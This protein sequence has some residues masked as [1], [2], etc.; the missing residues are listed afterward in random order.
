MQSV[1]RAPSRLVALGLLLCL[2]V[3][4][5]G[6]RSLS[7]GRSEAAAAKPA[8]PVQTPHDSAARAD[9]SDKTAPRNGST[10]GEPAWL[11]KGSDIP[12][13]PSWRFGVLPNGLRY[14][15]RRN[16]VPPGQVAVRVRIDAGSLMEGESE[17]GF[18]HLIEHLTFRGSI[19]VPDGEAKRLWQRLGTT[20][21]SDTNAQTTPTG[22]TYKLDLPAATTDGLDE[23]LKVMAGMMAQP[24]ITAAALTAERPVVL[25]EQREQPGPQVRIGDAVRKTLFAGQPLADRSPIGNIK[26]LESATAET[27]KAFHDRWYRPERAVVIISGDLD[28]GLFEELVKKNFSSWKG[29]GTAPAEPDFGKPQP[30]EPH[31]A[32][33]VEPSIPA[34]VTYGVLRP[35]MYRDDTIIFNQKRM[36]DQLAVRLINRRLEQRARSGGSF[37]QA[38]VSLDDVSRS[39]NG[40]FVQVIPI[41]DDWEA[42]LRDV[43]AV[44]AD[45]Q[46]TPPTQ[47]DIDRE[48]TE[49]DAAMKALV[50]T[51]A[52]EPGARQAD[53]LGDA[54]DIRETVTT[55]QTSYDI[56]RDAEDKHM[57][58]PETILASSKRVF[59][60]DAVRGLV[61]TRTP[62][63][64]AAARLET[65]LAA[66]VSN[67]AVK[68]N[69]L[70]KVTFADLPRL[71]KPSKIVG[72]KPLAAGTGVQIERIDFA[73]GVRLMVY[74]NAAEAGRVY[75]RVRFG[76]GYNA[77]PADRTTMVWA[78]SSAL[79][80]G[81]IGKLGQEELD[82]LTTGRRIGLSFSVDD[83]AFLFSGLT[84]ADDLRDQLT[85]MAAELIAP[86]WN[87]QPVE[88]AKAGAA[89][90][91]ATFDSSPSGVLSRDLEALLRAND[92]RWR[93]PTLAEIEASTP[94]DFRKAL[95]PILAS[96]PIEVQVFGDVKREAAIDAVA[97]SLGAIPKRRA[98]SVAPPPVRFPET[99]KPPLI[100]THG[101]PENQAVAVVAWPTAGGIERIT[102]SSRLDVLAQIFSDRLYDRLRSEAGASYSPSVQS[103]WPIGLPGGGRFVVIG[104]VT[105]DKVDF[106]FRLSREIAADL[107]ANPI[108]PDEL[109][110]TL[111]PY[112]Q[113]LARSAT[114]NTFWLTKLA[115]GTFDER[116][117]AATKAL[118]DDVNSITPEQLQQTARQYLQP[119]GAWTMA[120]VPKAL[121]TRPVAGPKR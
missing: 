66:N 96:G 28:P 12:P 72:R 61:N 107:I 17:R 14:A 10:S 64:T 8:E 98:S 46:A 106:L 9:A 16:G 27:V 83:D 73:N 119:D 69:T 52:A 90:A 80:A 87:P 121:A 78:A 50:D 18:A 71:G 15:V 67:V 34:L 2:A 13:D 37:L 118:G 58:T 108:G 20:F 101:G 104:Q 102:D 115:G 85:I 44:I 77:L 25:A 94:A 75:V 57:F 5:S 97:R 1:F 92:P 31:T 23:S 74:P 120:V 56:L 7:T 110:R 114:G 113:L 59:E 42:A 35:W 70:T 38:N 54:I 33:S 60:G 40:T 29:I 30:A 93:T 48:L 100:L 82:E 84:S 6:Q 105:P 53:N 89:A 111:L 79:V 95:A 68:R 86:G 4:L 36:V 103:D 116:R 11:Y 63:A 49:F 65:A 39:V 32:A 88:R 55:P 3:P 21:G 41:G 43:R 51:A 45:A 22:T 76:G 109:K 19:Y 117:V 99:G 62:D 91:Y 81:G 47:A 24:T 112:I 26:A